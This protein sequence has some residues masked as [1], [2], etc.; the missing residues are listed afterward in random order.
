MVEVTVGPVIGKIDHE[1]ARVLLEV[2]AE[3]EVTCVATQVDGTHEVDR[4]EAFEPHRARVIELEGLRASTRYRIV[5]RGAKCD[6][7]GRITT[8]AAQPDRLNALAVAG[9]L[10]VH[11]GTQDLWEDLWQRYVAPAKP[12]VDLLIHA[13]N[14]VWGDL[15]FQEALTRLGPKREGSARLEQRILERYRDLYRMAWRHP[16]TRRVLANVPNLMVWNDHEIRQGWGGRPGDAD[17]QS[18]ARW[19]AR[20]ARQVYREYQRELWDSC[21]PDATPPSGFEHHVHRLGGIGLVFLDVR[22]GRSFEPDAARPFLGTPQWEQLGAALSDAGELAGIRGL[23][24][25]CPVPLAWFGGQPSA[26]LEGFTDHFSHRDHRKEQVELLRAL[27]RWK[28]A[29]DKREVLAVV[30]G[31]GAGAA[32][33]LRHQGTRLFDQLVL[34]PVSDS[35]VGEIELE[36]LRKHLVGTRQRLGSAY[37]AEHEQ[38]V[39][40]RCYGVVAVRA[41][42]AEAA[43]ITFGLETD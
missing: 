31:V 26:W 25:V 14:Q 42:P 7:E 18:G 22:G 6:V 35:P 17:G 27:R 11:R 13:G 40:K 36:G 12:A 4:T 32:S 33:E 9:N 28:Q 34:G 20:L 23:V 37:E 43:T 21:E 15:A 19:V 1:R 8:Y 39:A 10:V 41:P 38:I 16:P 29:N 3:A 30:A 24:V 5:I 2:D